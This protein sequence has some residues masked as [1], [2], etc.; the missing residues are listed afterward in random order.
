M[1]NPVMAEA[2]LTSKLERWLPVLFIAMGHEHDGVVCVDT[3]FG[4]QPGLY[5]QHPL[6]FGE[7][8][9]KRKLLAPIDD[10]DTPAEKARHAYQRSYIVTG[11]KNNQTL[12]RRQPFHKGILD[13]A[14]QSCVNHRCGKTIAPENYFTCR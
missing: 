9:A 6:C 8:F 2:S 4:N 5:R 3:D 14:G 12:R 7:S 1:D 13:L 10:R 11:A